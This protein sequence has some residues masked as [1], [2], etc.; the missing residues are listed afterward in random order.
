LRQLELLQTKQKYKY[1]KKCTYCEGIFN[2]YNFYDK[3]NRCKRCCIHLAYINKKD[4]RKLGVPYHSEKDNKKRRLQRKID[5]AKILGLSVT[6]YENYLFEKQKHQNNKIILKKLIKRLNSSQ[7]KITRV[8]RLV[9][10]FNISDVQLRNL[11]KDYPSNHTLIYRIRYRY[12]L[13]FNIREKLRRHI[14]K[15][16]YKYPNLQ[17]TLRQCL[18]KNINSKHFEMLGYSQNDLK[19]HLE[20]KFSKDMSWDL[21]LSGQIHIDHIKPQSLFNLNDESQIIECWS[22]KNLQPLWAKDNLRKGNKY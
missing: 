22:L 20:S 7:N 11:T 19:K 6:Q 10:K 8:H 15:S 18:K 3:S 14:Q 4:K 17:H 9:Y 16:K 13:D 12:D 2:I 5:K 1:Y 21:F